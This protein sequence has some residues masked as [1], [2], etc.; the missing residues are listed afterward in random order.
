MSDLLFV[1][2]GLGCIA[3][4]VSW[5]FMKKQY[6][7]GPIRLS[8]EITAAD[9]VPFPHSKN[10]GQFY[11]VGPMLADTRAR[12]IVLRTLSNV[13]VEYSPDIICCID[14]KGYTL[15][16]C[17]ADRLGIPYVLVQN[18]NETP[19][20]VL[21]ADSSD[22]LEI[23]ADIMDGLVLTCKEKQKRVLIMDNF[24]ATG[25]SI[26]NLITL[27]V[28]A[29]GND[30]EIVACVALMQLSAFSVFQKGLYEKYP[31]IKFRTIFTEDVIKKNRNPF[32]P[33][34]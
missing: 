30:I 27:L 11:D 7:Y 16:A 33:P 28:E 5:L 23:P 9:R 20:G 31:S 34:E 6:L 19:G 8:T 26:D 24:I 4:V 15:G 22:E 12:D 14:C 3:L 25:R 17:V 1:V 13:V 18:I 10:I 29:Y 32:A 2:F 21:Q